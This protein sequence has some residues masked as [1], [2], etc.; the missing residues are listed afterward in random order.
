MSLNKRQVLLKATL[1]N[2]VDIQFTS[3][4]FY[5]AWKRFIYLLCFKNNLYNFVPIFYQTLYKYNFVLD[6]KT[7]STN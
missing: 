6:Y 7:Y 3:A 2:F 1:N 4:N 5:F